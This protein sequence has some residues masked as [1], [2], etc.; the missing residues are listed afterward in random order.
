ME[1]PSNTSANIKQVPVVQ[2]QHSHVVLYHFVGL[3]Q[4][5]GSLDVLQCLRGII[6]KH[7]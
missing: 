1:H 2:L 6:C 5:T 3:I 7:E 4:C